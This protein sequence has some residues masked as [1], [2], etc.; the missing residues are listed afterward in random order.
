MFAAALPIENLEADAVTEMD[1]LRLLGLS[2][3]TRC[4]GCPR[5]EALRDAWE[6]RSPL[7]AP[8]P[9]PPRDCRHQVCAPLIRRLGAGHPAI[10]QTPGSG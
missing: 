1:G 3:I 5:L 7:H 2:R 4:E 9:T 6:R 10:G 8:W